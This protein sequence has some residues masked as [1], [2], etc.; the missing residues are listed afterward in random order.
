ME[1]KLPAE[2]E[3]KLN[4]IDRKYSKKSGEIGEEVLGIMESA[5]SNT[6]DFLDYKKQEPF[7]QRE[8]TNR[9]KEVNK[10]EEIKTN[11]NNIEVAETA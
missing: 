5:Q 1:R 10:I 4:N 3:Q 2:L 6:A 9:E 8:C 7:L 11:I